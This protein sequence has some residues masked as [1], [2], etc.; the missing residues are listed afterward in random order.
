MTEKV[1]RILLRDIG[2]NLRSLQDYFNSAKDKAS[3]QEDHQQPPH[4]VNIESEIRLPPPIHDYYSAENK[5]RPASNRREH[6]KLFIEGAA[7]VAAIIAGVMAY[8][9]FREAHRQADAAEGQLKAVVRDFQVEQRALI[10]PNISVNPQARIGEPIPVFLTFTNTGK[11]V[12]LN[13]ETDVA[14][15][16]VK[17]GQQFEFSYKPHFHGE[18]KILFPQKGDPQLLSVQIEGTPGAGKF[19]T[20]TGALLKA[21]QEGDRAVIVYARLK[22]TDVFK[23]DH[24]EKVCLMSSPRPDKMQPI[25]QCAQYNDMDHN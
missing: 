21:L 15:R 9:T 5:E 23:T 1:L 4:K 12:A 10:V 20:L 13:F 7:L 6:I 14:I 22:Y 3:A 8:T 24:W 18:Q 16:I 19:V 17:R 25:D 11:T 2:N